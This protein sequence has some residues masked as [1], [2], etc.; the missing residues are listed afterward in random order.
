MLPEETLRDLRRLVQQYPDNLV[1]F[2][3]FLGETLDSAVIVSC[4]VNFVWAVQGKPFQVPQA[5]GS[6]KGEGMGNT[7]YRNDPAKMLDITYLAQAELRRAWGSLCDQAK[8]AK[9]PP[10]VAPERWKAA[11]DVW[12]GAAAILQEYGEEDSST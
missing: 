8:A 1:P 11:R 10:P 7:T 6:P 3:P 12:R 9:Q 5:T 2:Q 4:W